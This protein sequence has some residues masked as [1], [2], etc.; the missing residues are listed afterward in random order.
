MAKPALKQPPQDPSSF[1]LGLLASRARIEPPAGRL[2]AIGLVLAALLYGIGL[3]Y[4]L[5]FGDF[6]HLSAR[7]LEGY[8]RALPVPGTDWLADASFGWWSLAAGSDWFWH[9]VLNLGL[10]CLAVALAC[11]VFRRLSRGESPLA[12]GWLGFVAATL[13]ALHPAAVYCVAYLSARAS[14]LAGLFALAAL[15]S[16]LRAL[17]DHW[18]G[19]WVVGPAACAGALLSTPNAIALPAAMAF[20]IVAST[21]TPSRARRIAW[22][23]VAIAAA[24]AA[25]YI[26]AWLHTGAPAAPASGGYFDALAASSSRLLRYLGYWLVPVTAWMAIDMPE[27]AI[28]LRDAW[29]GWL[30]LAGLAA[31]LA[32]IAALLR[33][34][35]YRPVGLALGCAVI[36][37]APALLWPRLA[38]PLALPLGYAWMPVSVLALAGSIARLPARAAVITALACV[39]LWAALAAQTLQSF[40]SHGGVWDDAIR[41]AE[42]FGARAEDARLYINRATLHRSEGHTLAALADY[43]RA[44]VLQP[45]QP[46]ALR[47]RA[48]TYID[49]KR[50]AQALRDL[51]RLL[52]VEPE[53]AITHADRGLALMQ[54][55]RLD[56]AG[57][58]FDRAIERGVRQPRVFLNRGLA[59]LQ[60]GGLGAAP[61]A[62]ADIER[63]LALDPNYALA[64]FNRALIFEQ[65]ARTGMRLRDALTPELMRAVAAQNLSRA[66]QLGHGGACDQERATKEKPMP[67]AT[68]P[69]TPDTPRDRG[70]PA[71]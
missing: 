18:R 53:Q 6:A 30:G 7:Q 34:P 67:G 48:Q 51:D 62:L 29:P 17:D 10:H 8:A 61:M 2:V 40:S 15:W 49:D 5:V 14:L 66:C 12:A 44:L 27:P 54:A 52:V 32:A 57:R 58:A 25:A 43:D 63:A 69:L 47:G 38:A 65:A 16:T 3:R 20:L 68:L 71:P 11:G 21:P 64:Y 70:L 28:A 4:P 1:S 33:R 36:L 23:S 41:R 46:R 59:R 42:R 45:D 22:G 37:Y 56:E 35:G 26:A 31:L 9:R 50:Y 13:F 24:L 39:V 60:L 19:A 55:G